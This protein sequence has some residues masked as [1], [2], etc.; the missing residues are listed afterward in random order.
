V[1]WTFRTV[2]LLPKLKQFFIK[3]F[4]LDFQ[5]F[6]CKLQQSFLCSP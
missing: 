1:L 6:D 3:P 2:Q 4:A 5:T